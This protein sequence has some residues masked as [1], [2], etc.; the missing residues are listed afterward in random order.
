LDK[1]GLGEIRQKRDRQ[2]AFEG[3]NGNKAHLGILTAGT[4][5]EHEG[6]RKS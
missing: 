5:I 1:M 6:Y 2:K 3:I 4:T